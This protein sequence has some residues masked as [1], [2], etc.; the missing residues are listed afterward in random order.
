MQDQGWKLIVSENPKKDWLFNLSQD[1][2]EKTNLAAQ[3]PQEVARL[4]G[5]LQAHNAQMPAPLWPSFLQM[6]V[7]IDKTLDQKES[8][9]DE[10]TYWIN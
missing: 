7:S 3:R 9:D 6:P 10:Y 8:A 4:K 5:L 2:T 1:P